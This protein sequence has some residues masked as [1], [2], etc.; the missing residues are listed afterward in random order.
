MKVRVQKV[1]EFLATAVLEDW[2]VKLLSL[3][4]AVGLWA[5]VQSGL[6]VDVRLKAEV[7]YIWP[8]SLA[9]YEDVPS[10][11]QLTVQ[12]PQAQVR[13]LER[14]RPVVTVDLTGAAEG[15]NTVDFGAAPIKGIPEGVH[16]AHISPPSVDVRFERRASRRVPVR[17]ALAGEIA[18]GYRLISAKATPSAVEVSG[19][20][21]L[22]RALPDLPTEPIDLSELKESQTVSAPLSP[23][24]RALVLESGSAV[25][26]A[27]SVEAVLAERHFEQV[28]VTVDKEGWRA[29]A[30]TMHVVLSGPV[31]ELDRLNASRLSVT[32]H[33]PEPEPPG[34]ARLSA[35]GE[36]PGAIEVR[37]PEGS[38][39]K[40]KRL[41][42]ESVP[43]ERA[44]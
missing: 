29:G 15:S 31:A 40:V 44:P 21:S 33:V 11:V 3:L 20:R 4:I 37:L 1:L 8:E 24:S 25:Q 14:E 26:V 39:I 32:L 42:P 18:S 35:L 22:I 27:L 16:L 9:R 41:D 10:S 2:A 17:V 5:Y 23:S 12:G 28:P 30:G 36:G 38:A 13:R 19:P 34:K 7:Q 43:I 6:L